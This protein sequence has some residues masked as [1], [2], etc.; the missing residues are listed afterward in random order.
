MPRK[1]HQKQPATEDASTF[2]DNLWNKEW[3]DLAAI[4]PSCRT[5]YRLMMKLF[6]KHNLHGKIL[7]IGCGS[8]DFLGLLQKD[9]RN[10]LYGMDVSTAALELAKQRSFIKTTFVGDLTNEKHVAHLPHGT[11]DVIVASEVLEHIPDY[12][13]AIANVHRMLANGGS[14]VI[15]VPYRQK[16]WTAHDDFSGHVRRFEPGQLEAALKEKGFSIVSSHSWGCLLYNAYYHFFLRK[17]DPKK[18]MANATSR[19][20]RWMSSLLYHALKIDDVFSFGQQG[21][22]LIILA[23]KA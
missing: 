16:Y 14:F 9:A 2:Y 1:D 5:R 13:K 22:R 19:L 4:G 7:D 8:G 20:K 3:K 12:E 17:Q 23:R 6:K 21:R 11:F 10:T 18:V 15:T